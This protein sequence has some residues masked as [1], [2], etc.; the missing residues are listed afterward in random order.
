MVSSADGTPLLLRRLAAD[1]ASEAVVLVGH[2][3]T[4]HSRLLDGSMR[5]IAQA[6]V[7]AGVGY[8]RGHDSSVSAR[9]QPAHLEPVGGWRHLLE[10]MAAFSR[11]AFDGVE[12]DRRLLVRGTFSSRLML[13]LVSRDPELV[14]HLVTAGPF[15]VSQPSCASPAFSFA[16]GH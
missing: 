8:P 3:R 4:V 9:T 15:P 7:G 1:K 14:R 2:G 13:E 16:C 12:P 10:D 11:V 5:T 6:R